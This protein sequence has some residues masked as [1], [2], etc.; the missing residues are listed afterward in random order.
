[1]KGAIESAD[2]N[3]MKFQKNKH[4]GHNDWYRSIGNSVRILHSF[5]KAEYKMGLVF[6][7]NGTGN[8]NDLAK[9]N[10]TAPSQSQSHQ[11]SS[12]QQHSAP[13]GQKPVAPKKP[14]KELQTINWIVSNYEK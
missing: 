2:F 8:W 4:Q 5:T 11:Q 12:S 1:M 9:G 10:V 13:Q 7:A 3:A 14:K 6:D